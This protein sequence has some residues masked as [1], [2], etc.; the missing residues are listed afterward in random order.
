MKCKSGR[1]SMR[2]ISASSSSLALSRSPPTALCSFPSTFGDM[3]GSVSFTSFIS[4]RCSSLAFFI[5]LRRRTH[6]RTP[7]T[8]TTRTTHTTTTEKKEE[9]RKKN[10]RTNEPARTAE[11]ETGS[12]LECAVVS[13]DACETGKWGAA[14]E[15]GNSYLMRRLAQDARHGNYDP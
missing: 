9:R 7:A 2:G 4:S 3:T 15:T 10:E 13:T 8:V 5:F 14:A 1:V 12:R 11:A 6:V